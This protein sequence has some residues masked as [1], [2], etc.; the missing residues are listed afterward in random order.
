MSHLVIKKE[1]VWPTN[2]AAWGV[3]YWLVCINLDD[4][5]LFTLSPNHNIHKG[6]GVYQRWSKC[7]LRSRNVS[8]MHFPAIWRPKF[9]KFSPWCPTDS[10]SIIEFSFWEKMAVEKSGCIK[11][12]IDSSLWWSWTPF[13]HLMQLCQFH[14]SQ[15]V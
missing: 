8:E 7:G 3:C 15:C 14:I 6:N 2:K 5:I 13:L 9:Q 12:C 10:A 4:R 1:L 11:A